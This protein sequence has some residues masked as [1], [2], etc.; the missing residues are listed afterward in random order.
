MT[1]IAA[2]HSVVAAVLVIFLVIFLVGGAK[3]NKIT[4]GQIYATI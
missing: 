4:V 1:S 2:I 3:H